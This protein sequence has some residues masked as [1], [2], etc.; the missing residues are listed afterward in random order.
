VVK[1][2]YTAKL[3]KFF[4]LSAQNIL[5]FLF[6]CRQSSLVLL[7]WTHITNVF[8]IQEK[9]ENYVL[10]VESAEKSDTLQAWRQSNSCCLLQN[11]SLLSK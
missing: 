7:N 3:N 5:K 6:W 9:Q 11:S 4:S 2:T 8:R 10:K 1:N